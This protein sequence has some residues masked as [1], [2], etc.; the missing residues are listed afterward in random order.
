[1][2]P[3]GYKYY[4]N[5]LYNMPLCYNCDSKKFKISTVLGSCCNDQYNKEKYPFLKTP[6]YAF[7]N[8]FLDRKN[9]FNEKF[10]KTKVDSIDIKCENIVI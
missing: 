2:K 6:D 4:T 8:D 7:E 10:C 9:F 5:N 3:I 1:M